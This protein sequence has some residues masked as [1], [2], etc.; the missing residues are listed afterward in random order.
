MVE[1]RTTDQ[2]R[3]MAYLGTNPKYFAT[4]VPTPLAKSVVVEFLSA[5]LKSPQS[6]ESLRKLVRLA[7]FYDAREVAPAFQA[8]LREHDRAPVD[9]AKAALAIMALSWI[10]DDQQKQKSQSYFESLLKGFPDQRHRNSM[11]E[12]SDALGPREGTQALRA[13]IQQGIAQLRSNLER[14][15][16]QK[17]ADEAESS[18]DQIDELEE[19][20]AVDID[21]QDRANEIRKLIEAAPSADESIPRIELLYIGEAPDATPRLSD[22]AAMELVRV[23][24]PTRNY[25]ARIAEEFVSISQR[26][27]SVQ[28]KQ[29]TQA[30]LFRA[31]SLRAAA[32]FGHQLNE[33]DSSWLA[34]QPDAGSDPLA[35]RPNWQYAAAVRAEQ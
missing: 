23:A 5:A 4:P 34:K 9:T 28:G 22:W 15:R 11:L 10:G 26:Y 3:L 24:D 6:P 8:L 29:R 32:F 1:L 35:L 2:D 18:E 12:A 16:Q 30:A 31:R 33:P 27:P 19:F 21:A 17:Q 25:R 7:V 13:W 20:I 14:H